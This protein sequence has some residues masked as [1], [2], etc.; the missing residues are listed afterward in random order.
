MQQRA[1]EF[2]SIVDRHK[3]IRSSMGERMA[4]LDEA[5]FNVRRAGSLLA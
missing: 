1:I 5:V 4:E 3:R 2:N